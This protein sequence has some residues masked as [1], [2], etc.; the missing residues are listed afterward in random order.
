[1]QGA[2]DVV[3]RICRHGTLP[4]VCKQL[5]VID[6][7]NEGL[8]FPCTLVV[9]E[10]GRLGTTSILWRGEIVSYVSTVGILVLRFRVVRIWKPDRALADI[11]RRHRAVSDENAA[12]VDGVTATAGVSTAA[13]R[14]LVAV[15]V[16]DLSARAGNRRF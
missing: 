5:L 10:L 15:L 2:S 16:V 9:S 7:F 4:S 3:S 6:D 12:R 14:G 13:V 11:S 1:M 8:P